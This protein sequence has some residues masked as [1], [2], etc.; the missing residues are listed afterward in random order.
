MDAERDLP[1]GGY[2]RRNDD[3]A[4]RAEAWARSVFLG[5]ES[6]YQ[7]AGKRDCEDTRG[8]KSVH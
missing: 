1:I 2:L 8:N 6:L 7:Q 5:G 4:L 3:R